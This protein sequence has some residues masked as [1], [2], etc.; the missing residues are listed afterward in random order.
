MMNY[1][2]VNELPLQRSRHITPIL[3][4]EDITQ[5]APEIFLFIPY[6]DLPLVS[7]QLL[8]ATEWTFFSQLVICFG[9]TLANLRQTFPSIPGQN[10]LSETLHELRVTLTLI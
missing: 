6:R 4:T 1:D 10:N 5:E 9:Q 7:R 8:K 2:R 3:G